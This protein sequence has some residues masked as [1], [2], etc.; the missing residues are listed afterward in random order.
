MTGSDRRSE[1]EK[2]L[3]GEWY[4]AVGREIIDDQHRTHILLHNYNSTLP[5][6]ADRRAAL[7]R[8]LLGSIGEDTVI[9]PPF[10]CDYGTNISLGKGVFLNFGCVFLDVVAIEVGD[11]CQIGT[12]V[13]VLT[14]DHPRDPEMRSQ[15][16]E[17]GVPVRIGRNVWIGSGAI[18]LPGI[19]IGDDAIVGAGSVVTRDVPPGATVMGNPARLS[20]KKG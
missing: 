18:I 9:R 17:R 2:M 15:S 19:S 11:L 12:M 14:A 6:E 16:Y 7:L 8:D 20:V 5:D 4:R 13:Q 10:Y 3:A 1:K